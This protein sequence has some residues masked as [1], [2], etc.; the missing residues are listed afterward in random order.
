MPALS[1]GMFDFFYAQHTLVCWCV[2]LAELLFWES[3]A[4][5]LQSVREQLQV[6]MRVHVNV[7]PQCCSCATS[8]C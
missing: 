2:S 7:G 8:S 3:K 5:N 4:K 6:W 1:R